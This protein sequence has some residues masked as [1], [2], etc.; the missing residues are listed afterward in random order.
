[1]DEGDLSG[2][3]ERPGKAILGPLSD[4]GDGQPSRKRGPEAAVGNTVLVTP[5]R[6]MP[7]RGL[8]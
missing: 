5:N 8:R 2:G 3:E 1:M 7:I 4:H 6:A